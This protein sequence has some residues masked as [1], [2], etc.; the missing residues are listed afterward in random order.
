MGLML[1][2]FVIGWKREGTAALLIASGWTLWHISEGRFGLN[3]FQTPLPVV[4][5][6]GLY[7]WA[8]QGRRTR[9]VVGTIS[10]LAV[11]LCLGRLFCRAAFLFGEW[12]LTL[13]PVCRF[14]TRN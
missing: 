7:W 2:G 1:V 12:L 14:P 11:A 5:L 4:A 13:R 3:A 8:T 10:L 9:V 6:Y